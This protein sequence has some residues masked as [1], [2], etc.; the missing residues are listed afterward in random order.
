[1]S[2]YTLSLALAVVL[3]AG[4]QNLF[5]QMGTKPD[6]A[7]V[8]LAIS[9]AINMAMDVTAH[10][11][12]N[13]KTTGFKKARVHI[14]DG[15]ITDAPLIWKQGRSV[16]TNIPLDLVI[17][18]DGFFQIRQPNGDI[19]YTRNGSLH[20]NSDGTVVT[21]ERGMLEPQICIPQ[22]QSS[23]IINSDGTVEVMQ[24]GNSQPQQVGQIELTRFQNPS[25]LKSIGPTLFVETAASGQP[26]VTHPGENGAGKILQGFLED[27]NVEILEEL[28]TLR[29]L[30]SWKMGVDQALM[31]IQEGHK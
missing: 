29:T 10:N 8:L 3:L 24:S 31:A 23:I 25:G 20:L 19:A 9:D 30:Q 14:Q 26:M 28:T 13:F 11:I 4:C 12:A 15:R 2:R 1:M 27:S 17:D 22:D 18:G 5:A 16:I 21:S 7:G 6:K